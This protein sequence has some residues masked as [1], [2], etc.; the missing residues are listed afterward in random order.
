MK[1]K[2]LAI[3]LSAALASMAASASPTGVVISQVFGGGGSANTSLLYK[4]DF[5]ELFNAGSAPVAIGGWSVQYASSTGT[6]W[7]VTTIPAGVTLQPGQYYLVAESASGSYAGAAAVNG[8]ITGTIAMAAGAGKVALAKSATALTGTAPTNAEDVVGYGGSAS[9][10]GSLA[11]TLSVTLGALRNGG[12]CTDTNNNATDFTGGTPTPRN[13]SSATHLC[14]APVNAVIIPS[15]PAASAVLGTASSFSVT[16]TDADSRVNAASVTGT[17]PAGVTLGSFSPAA[18]DGGVATQQISVGANVPAGSYS[19]NLG[20]ANDDAQTASCTIALNVQGA[21]T[22]PQIQGTG[23]TSPMVGQTVTT[24]GVVTKLT[25]AGFFLQDVDSGNNPAVTGASSGIYVYTSTAPTVTV[26]HAVRLS[27]TVSEFNTGAASNADTLAHTVTELVSP[28]GITDLGATNAVMPV[29]LDLLTLPT[30]ALEAYEGMVVT[31]RGPLM[32]QQNYFYGRYGQLTIAAG[33]RVQT[34][35]N[36]L[37]PGAAARDL[38]AAN[39]ARSILLDDGS[40]LQNVNPVPFIGPDNTVRAGD[41]TG[42]ITGVIDYGLATS[43]NTEF[44]MYKIHPLDNAAVSFARTNPRQATPQVSGGNVRIASANVLNF[45]TSFT[46]GGFATGTAGCSLGGATSNGNCRGAD[47]ITEFNRQLAKTVAELSALNADVLGL[48][49]IQ[50]SGQTTVQYLV[51]QLNAKLGAGTYATVPVPSQGTGTDAIR[52]AMIYKPGKV[53][54]NGVTLSDA[55]AVNNRPPLAQGF[56]LPNGEKFAVVVNHLK[57]KSS[58]EDTSDGDDGLQGVCNLTR[59]KQA[60]RLKTFV[61]TVK[62]AAGT[63]D[64]VLLGDFN[65]YAKEDPVDALTSGGAIV[66]MVAAFDTDPNAPDYSY[67]FDGASGRLDHGFATAS[68]AP[69][70]VYATSWHINADEPSFIDYNTEFKVFGTSTTG[71]PDYYTATPYRSSDH[72]PMVLGLNL[73]NEISGGG[74]TIVGTPGDDVIEGGPGANTITGN[75]GHDVFVYRSIL[76]VGDTITDFN[77]A[78]DRLDLSGLLQSQ[79]V[80]S[81]DPLASGHVTCAT[82]AGS[83]VIG[84]DVDGSAGPAKSRAIVQL[85]GVACTALTA[86]NYKF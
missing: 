27:G 46:N 85:R 38:L 58:C 45:F 9:T 42:D 30:D 33:G 32:A 59:V 83:A 66:D 50:N 23:A 82:Q 7:Q 51:D 41:T 71:N 26:G 72:D 39:L 35:T 14:G 61:E 56:V 81:A 74:K 2:P 80:A 12:G 67:V 25:N 52:V 79:G 55:D 11:T 78:D 64:V 21:I 6:S 16:A 73:V 18:A 48:M 1:L 57:S 69:K 29:E 60:N 63:S 31:L 36:V 10:E 4:N 49:E 40:S 28:S 68:L 5:V 84:L 70:V 15:C 77:P 86:A 34:P 13:T 19:L 3:L 43:T 62:T 65:S 24:S 37:R 75:G 44:G 53:A 22:I 54:L 8:D 20:W 76:D 17:W 47:N